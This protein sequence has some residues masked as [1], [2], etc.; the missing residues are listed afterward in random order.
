QTISGVLAMY[1]SGLSPLTIRITG[2][3]NEAVTIRRS[4]VALIAENGA[5]IQTPAGSYGITV[6][7]AARDVGISGLSIFG[8]VGAALVTRGS[9][10]EFL[11]I[12]AEGSELG[13]VSSDNAVVD[14]NDSTI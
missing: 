7:K 3:C 9:Q 4:S 13:I 6:D 2:T 10:V 8:G 12:H 1:A 14:I 5:A 11:N